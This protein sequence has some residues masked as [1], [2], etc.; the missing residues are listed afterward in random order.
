MTLTNDVTECASH[1]LLIYR[2]R[3]LSEIPTNTTRAL[4]FQNEPIV[5]TNYHLSIAD[6]AEFAIMITGIIF[7]GIVSIISIVCIL[8]K[9]ENMCI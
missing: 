3:T 9:G 2:W 4:S 5:L 7:V 1:W 6:K 8:K